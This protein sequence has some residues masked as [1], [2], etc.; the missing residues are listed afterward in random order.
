MNPLQRPELPSCSQI[1]GERQRLR[2]RKKQRIL[3][4][5]TGIFLGLTLTAGAL[6]GSQRFTTLRITGTSMEPGLED[7]DLVVFA[8]CGQPAPGRICSFTWENRTLVKRI[9]G[10][11]G[12]WVQVD[13]TGRV[14]INGRHRPEPHIPEPAPG[15]T[16]VEFPCLVPGDSLFVMGD[17]RETSVDSRNTAIGPVPLDRVQGLAVFRLWP[18]EDFG[19]LA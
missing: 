4:A 16:D 5:L 8:R 15:P 19:P 1:A 7:G 13:P 3:K 12:D 2:R 9:I 18:L 17:R 6:Y 14:L 11:P 10:L